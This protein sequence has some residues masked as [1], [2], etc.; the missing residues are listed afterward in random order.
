MAL[1]SC[2][3]GLVYILSRLRDIEMF[4]VFMDQR[5]H[6]QPF[7]LLTKICPFVAFFLDYL[8]VG[9]Q[10]FFSLINRKYATTRP[11]GRFGEIP[12]I[13]VLIPCYDEP[14]EVIRDT[15]WAAANIHYPSEKFEVLLLDDMGATDRFELVKELG[16]QFSNVKYKS[17]ATENKGPLPKRKGFKAGN[18]NFG[19]SEARPDTQGFLLLDADH[20][21]KSEILH[22]LTPHGCDGGGNWDSQF[23]FVQAPQSYQCQPWDSWDRTCRE[24]HY[25]TQAYRAYWNG[26]ML[27]GTSALVSAQALREVG[28]FDES[29]VTEDILTGLK[30][31]GRGYK[32]YYHPGDVAYGLIP[33]T[34][35]SILRQRLRWSQ[36]SFQLLKKWWGLKA[37][38]SIMQNLAYLSGIIYFLLGFA[39][40]LLVLLPPLIL[41][42]NYDSSLHYSNISILLLLGFIASRYFSREIYCHKVTIEKSAGNYLGIVYSGVYIYAFFSALFSKRL[43]F[44]TTPKVA[45]DTGPQDS[46][47]LFLEGLPLFL[48]LANLYALCRIFYLSKFCDYPAK[49]F[50]TDYLGVTALAFYFFLCGLAPLIV[51]RSVQPRRAES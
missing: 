38:L 51:S 50:I 15:T 37:G 8:F 42:F 34:F 35:S 9:E 3:V 1:L 48:S 43:V 5:N 25:V 46:R 47:L 18:L 36:G 33:V 13:T 30:I 20:V 10:V 2:V 7:S 23:G 6:P 19:I 12:F 39:Y 22:D 26:V 49:N 21:C 29:T 17:R 45:K 16:S 27:T 31:H 44:H 41:L 4:Y 11:S 24:F 32:G 40:M 14:L 28:L